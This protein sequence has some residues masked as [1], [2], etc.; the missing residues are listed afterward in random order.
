M[1]ARFSA[2]AF[3]CSAA[4]SSLA[5]SSI[6]FSA[7]ELGRLGVGL[8][9]G[10]AAGLSLPLSLSAA[11]GFASSSPAVGVFAGQ[12]FE[13]GLGNQVGIEL[14]HDEQVA[15][16]SRARLFFARRIFLASFSPSLAGD[17]TEAEDVLRCRP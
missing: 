15:I 3:F 1:A 6:A 7:S 12:G 8:V 17:L 13:R 11:S 10:R 4:S 16:Q 14:G 5:C 2:S 9:C